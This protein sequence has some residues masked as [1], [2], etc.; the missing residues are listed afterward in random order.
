MNNLARRMNNLLSNDFYG[1]RRMGTMFDDLSSMWDELERSFGVSGL[2]SIGKAFFAPAM[3]IESF[4]DRVEITFEIPGMVKDNIDIS[5]DDGVLK[6]TGKKEQLESDEDKLR[7]VE[8][9]YYGAF[10]RHVTISDNLNA[11]GIDA[12][13]TDGVL[14]IT[15]PKLE[16]IE[17]EKS[18]KKIEIK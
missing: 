6:I 9:R 5:V 2:P 17:E 16:Q 7:Y 8:E 12:N 10:E 1:L 14:K 13:Y 11:D 18:A 4:K 15:I 3:D